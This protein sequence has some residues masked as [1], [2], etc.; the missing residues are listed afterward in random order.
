[1][2]END[3]SGLYEA[4]G[5]KKIFEDADRYREEQKKKTEE[6]FWKDI[7]NEKDIFD[8]PKIEIKKEDEIDPFW[9]T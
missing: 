4:S 2:D 9:L 7:E 8:E 3:T 6:S 1:M 5:L